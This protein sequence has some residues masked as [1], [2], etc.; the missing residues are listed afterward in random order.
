MNVW[1]L[2]IALLSHICP[3]HPKPARW[4]FNLEAVLATACFQAYYFVILSWGSSSKK[5][6]LLFPI[7][8]GS[9]SCCR[10]K[11]WP[12]S[13]IPECFGS[14]F[15]SEC[16]WIQQNGP[17]PSHFL[18]FVWQFPHTVE[19]PFHLLN[20]VQRSCV[21]NRRFR[22]RQASLSYSDVLAMAFSLKIFS[23]Q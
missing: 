15:G 12:F 17:R 21:M 20:G 8:F 9:L 2:W 10:M 18:L 19:P 14:C 6:K 11:P 13:C 22:F 7:G 3:V 16:L 5:S 1:H 4:G 23:S